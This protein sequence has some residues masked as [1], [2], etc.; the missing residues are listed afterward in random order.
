MARSGR[1]RGAATSWEATRC[2]PSFALEKAAVTSL[3]CSCVCER[4][5]TNAFASV[6]LFAFV[7]LRGGWEGGGRIL[8]AKRAC[9]GERG[10]SL[11]FPVCVCVCVCARA[12]LCVCACVC[13]LVCVCVRACVRACMHAPLL[14]RQKLLLQEQLVPLAERRSTRDRARDAWVQNVES[15]GAS[16]DARK[17]TIERTHSHRHMH[18]AGRLCTR[19]EHARFVWVRRVVRKTYA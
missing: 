13:V 18:D 16:I 11:H 10:R 2:P 19:Q 9:G 3:P 14:L 1:R 4:V 7:I 8:P 17:C 15:Q 6:S 5:C 12:R